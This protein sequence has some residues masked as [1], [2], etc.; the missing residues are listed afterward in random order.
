MITTIGGTDSLDL[1]Y[2]E[3]LSFLRY[4]FFIY[5]KIFFHNLLR[6]SGKLWFLITHAIV[7]SEKS[8]LE[9]EREEIGFYE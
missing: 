1:R 9:E 5:R 2:V 7:A 3:A 8:G 6:S 4:N